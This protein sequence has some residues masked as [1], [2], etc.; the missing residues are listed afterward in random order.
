MNLTHLICLSMQLSLCWIGLNEVEALL[1]LNLDLQ[2]YD[3][4]LYLSLIISKYSYDEI[5]NPEKNLLNL[6]IFEI[7][8]VKSL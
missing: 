5:F 4:E 3:K 6:Q 2:I 7:F 8:L 1:E